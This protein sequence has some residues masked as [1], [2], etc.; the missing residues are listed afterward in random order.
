[1]ESEEG[2]RVRSEEELGD[3]NRSGLMI[4]FCPGKSTPHNGVEGL[5]SCAAH[6]LVSCCDFSNKT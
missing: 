1:M 2:K 5:R 6:V 4:G 3:H